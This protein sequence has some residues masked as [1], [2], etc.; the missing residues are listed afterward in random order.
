MD[1]FERALDKLTGNEPETVTV[2]DLKGRAYGANPGLD[3][4]CREAGVKGDIGFLLLTFVATGDTVKNV[5]LSS[6]DSAAALR[7]NV[8]EVADSLVAFVVSPAYEPLVGNHGKKR[9]R[10]YSM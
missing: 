7:F 10:G 2:K 5:V 1:G 3:M 8:P 4:I 6:S 9:K